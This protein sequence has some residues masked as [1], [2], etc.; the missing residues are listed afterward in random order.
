VNKISKDTRFIH[1]L[2]DV[3]SKNIGEATTVWQF[4]IILANS[5]IGAGSVVTKN[6]PSNELWIGNPAKFVRKVEL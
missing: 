3:K 2:A 5:M 6:I 4:S 1:P